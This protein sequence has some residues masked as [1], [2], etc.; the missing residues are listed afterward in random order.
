MGIYIGLGLLI[1]ALSVYIFLSR[2]EDEGENI[3]EELPNIYV[4]REELEKLAAQ[5]SVHYSETKKTNIRRKLMKSLDAS[6]RKIMKGYEYIDKEIGN[7]GDILPAAEW[8][9]DNLYLIEKEY[10]DIKDNMPESYYRNLPIMSKGIMKKY[11]RIYQIAVEIVSHT[12]GIVDESTIET[13]INAYQKNIILTSGELWALPI[14]LRIALIQNITHIVEKI[15]YAIKEKKRA[16]EVADYIIN[17]MAEKHL[18]EEIAYLKKSRIRLSTHFVERVIKLLRDNGLDNEELYSWINDRLEAEHNNI[19]KTISMEH[20]KEAGYQLSLGN[21]ITSIRSIAALNWTDVFE[22]LSF[23]EQIL[24]EDPSGV[25]PQMDFE[26]RDY[27]RHKLEGLTR[28]NSIGEAYVANKLIECANDV[29]TGENESYKKH[30]G[31]YLIDDGIECL[32]EKIEF[33]EGFWKSLVRPLKSVPF[34][35][36]LMTIIAGILLLEA[37]VLLFSMFGDDQLHPWRYVLGAFALL[38]PSSEIIISI[39]N[40]GLNHLTTPRF[41]PKLTLEDGIPDESKTVVVIPTLLN[42]EHRVKELISDLEVYYLANQEKNLYFVLLGDFRDSTKEKEETD[43]AIVKTGLEAVKELNQKYSKDKEDI[44]YFLCRYR[45]FNEK[46]GIW[47]G[48]ERK[49]GKLMEFNALLSGKGNGSYHVMSGNLQDLAIKYVI[50]LDADTQLPRDAAKKLVGAMSHTLNRSYVDTASK[51]ILRGYGLMQP[52]ISVSITAANKT[53]FSRIFSGE[54]GTDIYTTAVSDV[55]QDVFGEGIFTGKG[56]Y[57]LATFETM[58]KDEIP[59]NTVLSHDLLEGSYVRCALVTDVELVDGYPAYYN[60]N[61]KRV[62]RWVRGD[63]QLLSWLFKKSPINTLSKWK[64]LDNLRRSLLSPSIVLL[65]VLALTVLPGDGRWIVVAFLAI[66]TPLVFDVSEAVVAPA[67]GINLT[68]RFH[69]VK[70]AAE[71]MFFMFCFIPFQAYQMVDAIIRTLYRLFISKK[72]LLEWQTAADAEA[73]SG[74]SFASYFHLMWSSCV[75]AVILY[76][77]AFLSSLPIAIILAIPCI[78]WFCSPFIAYRISKDSPSKEFVLNIENTEFL[79]RIGRKTWAYFEDFVNAENNWLAPDNFQ[80]NPP[81]G[82]ANRTS[83]TNI[84]MAFTSNLC[85]YDMDYI[86]FHELVERMDQ[87]LGST[88]RLDKFKGHLYN[89]YDTITRQPLYPRYVSTVDSGNMVAYMW[90]SSS[91]L[92]NYGD[93]PL[94]KSSYPRGLSDTIQ[95]ASMEIDSGYQE[96]YRELIHQENFSLKEWKEI[97]TSINQ[98]ASE[99]CKKKNLFWNQ[100]VSYE[101][102]K[103]MRELEIYAPWLIKEQFSQELYTELDSVLLKT[104]LKEAG[105]KLSGIRDRLSGQN[106]ELLYDCLTQAMNEINNIWNKAQELSVRFQKFVEDT[107][108][109][110]VF[111]KKRQLFSIGYDIEKD[112]I[113]NSYYDLMASEARCASYVAIAKGDVGQKHWFKLNRSMTLMG[114]RKGLVSWSGTMFEYFMPMLIMKNFNGS[115]MDETYAAVI[116]GQKRYCKERK[117]PWGISESAFYQFDNSLNYQYKAFGVPGIGLKR[118]LS[119]ELVIAPYATVITLQKDLNGALQNM[120]KLS[121]EGLEGR[122]G[123]YEAVDYTRERVPK[124]N[125]RMTV[126]CFMVHHEGMSLMALNN[127]LNHNILVEMF[128]KRPEVKATELLLQE[129]VQRSLTYEREAYAGSPHH[130]KK[131]N[132][133]IVRSYDSALTEIPETHIL[134]NGEFSMMITNSGSGYCKKDMM[135]AYRWREDSTTDGNGLFLYI[136]NLSNNDY[137][138]SAYEPCKKEGKDYQVIFSVDKAEF[139]RMDGDIQTHTEITISPEDDTEVRR[140]SLTNRGSNE[141]IL[142]VTSY[143]EITLAPYNAD[144]VHPA[145]SNL[146]ISTEFDEEA[147]C[148]LANRRPR[149]KGQTKPWMMQIINVEGESVSNLQYETSRLNFIGR[150]RT[151]ANPAVMDSNAPLQNNVGAVLDPVMSLRR[152]I[153]IKPGQTLRVAIATGIAFSREEAVSLAKK[154]QEYHNITRIFELAWTRSMLEMKYMNIKSTAVNLFQIMA[155]KIIYI[156]PLLKEREEFIKKISKHQKDL[157]PYGI[158]GD[159]PIVVLLIKQENDIDYVKR[160]LKAHEFWVNRGLAVDLVILNREDTSYLQPLQNTIRDLLSLRRNT[161]SGGIYLHNKNSMND[162]MMQFLLGIARLVIDTE[163]GS[164]IRQIRGK[165]NREKV[166]FVKVGNKENTVPDKEAVSFMRNNAGK[167]ENPKTTRRK[168]GNESQQNTFRWKRRPDYSVEFSSEL[169]AEYSRDTHH[170]YNKDNLLFFNGYGGFQKDSL[171]YVILLDQ[172]KNTPAPWINVISNSRFGFHVSER[173]S[174][175]TW[176]ENSREN[177]ITPWN[178]DYVSDIP[179]EVLYLRDETDGNY[180]SVSASPIRDNGLYAVEHGFGY[181]RFMHEAYGIEASETMFIPLEESCKIII[182]QMKNKTDKTR[183]LSATYYMHLVHGVVPQ[184]TSRYITTEINAKN[185]YIYSQ[186]PYSEHFGT[187]KSFLFMDG[188][189][190]ESFTGARNEFIGR[191]QNVFHPDGMRREKLSGLSGAGIDPCLAENMK[192]DLE[193]GEDKTL[194]VVIGQYETAAEIERCMRRFGNTIRA[195]DALQKVIDYWKELLGRIQVKTPDLSMDIMLNGWLMYQTL[196]CRYWSRSA[197]YQSGGAYGYRDQLQD[198]LAIGMLEPSLT[199]EQIVRS[200]SRQYLEGDVQH[201]W[202]PKVESGIRTRFS[203][204]RL[205]LPYVTARYIE[206]TGDE[207]ILDETA[208]Y[209]QDEPLQDGEDERYKIVEHSEVSGSIYEHCIKAIEISLQFGEHNIPL[210]GSGDWNDGYSTIGNQ[211]K[212]ESVWMGWFLF[213]ILDMFKKLSSKRGD[214][215]KYLHF[216]KMQSFIRENIEAQAWDGNWYKRAFF[217]DGT[218]LGSIENDECQIDSL[219]QSWAVISGGSDTNRRKTAMQSVGKYLVKED[220]GMILL[221]SPAFDNSTLEPGYIKGYVPGVRENGAQYSHAGIWV[222]LAEAMQK[223]GDK[224]WHYFNMINPVNHSET[225]LEAERYKVEPYVMS[226]DVYMKEPHTGRGGWSWYTGA[227]GWMYQVG[228]ESML[229][230]Q[231]KENKGFVIK[232][233]VPVGWEEYE[234][235]FRHGEGRY[236]IRVKKG[237]SFKILVD[238]KPVNG[239]LIPFSDGN[240]E[241]EIEHGN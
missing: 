166:N 224:A 161:N 119:G 236:H 234:I 122:Y 238:G 49:R 241:V 66:I 139:K 86:G 223:N 204:D 31:Y 5:I 112:C 89:W 208:H 114:S 68:G 190:N 170:H 101:S 65:I 74:K 46:Q 62:H 195:Y 164:F 155:S 30:I 141:V 98:I 97:L 225:T 239:D 81:N 103:F 47:L 165:E 121:A 1:L 39:L 167:E 129:K 91:A 108:F 38:I 92:M 213:N 24:K 60:A 41:I 217:D 127:A 22:R 82:L 178:N 6:F 54:T 157:W 61:A 64:I 151:L 128:H 150:G 183:K 168:R 201:W 214:R 232:P 53:I 162:E 179:G 163:R 233:S 231:L 3:L 193:P 203:D 136:K 59:E 146:F 29:T 212:G 76:F 211:G 171:S 132:S 138:S 173:G 131:K 2:K 222:I 152:R 113:N 154:Y 93:N 52:R 198:S 77:L 115:S 186:N 148:L 172:Y 9:L 100:K 37:F 202:H 207:T 42:N 134:S 218:P 144:I 142:E 70:M 73:K 120:K 71:Q 126:N 230:L 58:L 18:D 192:F 153:K 17:A 50:T 87:S 48:W 102:M 34:A 229:G 194:I 181:S 84:G 56:I 15:V 44:F 228:I 130:A 13:F 205:W 96:R 57:D 226:A 188:G 137:W 174:A 72:N 21:S 160:M 124:G 94:I 19:E 177:K 28:K 7:D 191:G 25:Y 8:L 33:R 219:A 220:K 118:G 175:Y 180:W 99:V 123:Y 133:V 106:R 145:F 209:L 20:H 158:S 125:R 159:L 184:D 80:E 110:V 83:P 143:C 140:I 197:F 215:D 11:A 196:S 216:E 135:F 176:A 32:K 51:K 45:Q 199:R 189:K 104:P 182:V 95:L 149:S 109:S 235:Y 63:W 55:Y 210:I 23:V 75:I 88:E 227:S 36:Y 107:D 4:N 16:E 117:V 12:D 206:R 85:A 105:L 78:L 67:K 240:H 221:L 111:D 14:M 237:E 69:G 26:S 10:K 35:M 147:G 200:A 90:L 185:R 116:D 40:W 27:Y 187:G 156:S 169:A 79:R 43:D